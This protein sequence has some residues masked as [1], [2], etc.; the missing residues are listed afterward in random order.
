M[1]NS[2]GKDA[3]NERSFYKNVQRFCIKTILD[4]RTDLILFCFLIMASIKFVSSIEAIMDIGVADEG[5]YLYS[6]VKLIESGLPSAQWGP[7]YAIWYYLLSLLEKDNISLFYL[8]YKILI[9]LTTLALYIC[10]RRIKVNPF[11]SIISSFFYL[12]SAIPQLF[13]HV[14]HFS[15]LILLLFFILS[16]FARSEEKHHFLLGIGILLLSLVR[17]EYYI[18]F[19]VFCL[20]FLYFILQKIKAGLIKYN[21]GLLIMFSFS[22]IVLLQL[23]FFGNPL[24]GD[25]VWLAFGQHFSVNFI[26]R[27]NLSINPWTNWEQITKSVFGDANNIISAALS[28]S[29]EFF[30]HILCNTVGYVISLI[31]M[32]L[33][34][35][36]NLTPPIF[37]KLFRR[38]EFLFGIIIIIYLFKVRHE[39]K[40]VSD[41]KVIGH[42]LFIAVFISIPTILA[43]LVFDPNY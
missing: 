25:R 33:S 42:L 21:S 43:A 11:V 17:P 31:N 22:A 35:L 10:L 34:A 12:I 26:S 3:I 1:N 20:V 6:G 24:Y 2:I 4:K 40:K 23:Y 7:L 37:N 41:N 38:M 19:L 18:S 36:Q 30:R 5:Y 13:V 39:I 28:N 14:M 27:H 32:P 15:L 29:K 9:C 8:N 16:T